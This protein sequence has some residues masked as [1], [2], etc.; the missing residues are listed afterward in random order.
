[1]PKIPKRTMREFDALYNEFDKWPMELTYRVYADIIDDINKALEGNDEES[2]DDD[3][4]S[5]STDA[6]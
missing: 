3:G 6:D 5:N 2:I 1:M 4:A